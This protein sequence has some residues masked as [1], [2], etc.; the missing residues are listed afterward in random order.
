M[1]QIPI[2]DSEGKPV[3]YAHLVDGNLKFE[4]EYYERTKGE[5]DY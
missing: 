5:G 2:L 4:F 3:R 1:E